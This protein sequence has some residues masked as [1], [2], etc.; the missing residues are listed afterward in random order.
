MGFIL[1][2]RRVLVLSKNDEKVSTRLRQVNDSYCL[3]D[4]HFFILHNSVKIPRYYKAGE[5]R[6]LSHSQYQVLHLMSD[7]DAMGSI[8]SHSLK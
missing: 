3:S 6:N 1:P 2:L 7:N 4:P 8:Y 5:V